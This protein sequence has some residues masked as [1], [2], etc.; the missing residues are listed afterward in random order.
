MS[1]DAQKAREQNKK[2]KFKEEL[3]KRALAEQRKIDAKKKK[4]L[5]EANKEL[6]LAIKEKRILD[7][8]IEAAKRAALSREE[9]RVATEK[10][11]KQMLARRNAASRMRDSL[12]NEAKLIAERLAPLQAGIT[13]REKKTKTLEVEIADLKS[14][15][16]PL[17]QDYVRKN[18]A[19][20]RADFQAKSYTHVKRIEKR[21]EGTKLKKEA[22]E[23]KLKVKE[24]YLH[25]LGK[26]RQLNIYR[27]K[28]AVLEE[29][30][31]NLDTTTVDAKEL[32]RILIIQY[33]QIE[34][35]I[36]ATQ[37]ELEEITVNISKKEDEYNADLMLAATQKEKFMKEEE[38][39]K[40]DE[41]MSPDE[42]ATRIELM[43]KQ[44]KNASTGA[45]QA[46]LESQMEELQRQLPEGIH[47]EI[48][49]ENNRT[50]K[51][52]IV[53]KD[54]EVDIYKMVMYSWGAAYYFR[55]GVAITKMRF[56][57]ET[58]Y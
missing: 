16:L 7:R 36:A 49:Y 46:E 13:T 52:Y 2:D 27:Q 53:S 15:E 8:K 28:I 44:Y 1:I 6:D 24:N 4:A 57:S 38:K 12:S 50:I 40:A 31:R 58:K 56:D 21:A 43:K 48:I 32:N 41:T 42:I 45:D 54:G 37:K 51:K 11:Q 39:R 14:A 17:L 25:R 26:E 29:R 9:K 22:L 3:K 34:K 35:S 47:E 5:V 33:N 20:N 30:I 10:I 19:G 18:Q 23:I 55:N